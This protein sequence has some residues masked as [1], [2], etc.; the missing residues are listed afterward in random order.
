MTLIRRG[1]VMAAAMVIGLSLAACG[2]NLTQGGSGSNGSGTTGTINLGMLT[3][4]TGSS[5]AIGPN[6]QNGAQLAVDEIN[7]QGGVGGRKLALTVSDEGC[8]PRTA[9]AGAAKLVSDHID[10]SVGGYCSSATLPTLSIFNK[11]NIPM[12]IPAANSADLVAQKLPNVF[13]INGTGVQQAEAASKFIKSQGST[14][15]ALLDDNT[16]YSTDI[17]KRAGQDLQS[18]G[19][20]VVTH[21]SVTA[22]ESNYSGAVNA[23]MSSHADFVYWT[24][25]YQEGGLIIKQLKAAGYQGK[26]MVADGTVDE[27]LVQI[28]GQ[29]NA[30]GVFA[31]MTETPQTVP[32]GQAWVKKYQDKFGSAP[33]PYSTQSYDAVRVAAEAVRLAGS[34]D[35][36]AVT[37]ALMQI[38][39]FK[40]FSGPLQFTPEHTLTE[41]GFDILVVRGDDFALNK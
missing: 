25:Y 23:V 1:A 14:A 39:G 11:A 2:N 8:D 4:L 40:L 35:G 13:M 36:Q 19:V 31:T 33:G 3:P 16:S 17:A 41:G 34:T 29:Q 6:M 28:A 30:Q 32:D 10:I 38:N 15:V 24:G 22:G 9:A 20:N 5:A 12:I 7:A 26:I 37:K 27:K 18:L 21:Q